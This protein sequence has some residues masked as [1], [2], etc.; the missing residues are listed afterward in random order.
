VGDAGEALHRGIPSNDVEA[1]VG[2]DHRVVESLDQA[3]SENFHGS[4][5]YN[6][7]TALHRSG[8]DI[9]MSM[10]KQPFALWRLKASGFS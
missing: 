3:M 4:D 5:E 10:G 9:A 8:I 2:H 1:G 7:Y 6:S